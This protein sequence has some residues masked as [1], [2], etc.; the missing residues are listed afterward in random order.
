MANDISPM[1]ARL[2]GVEEA[3]FY[4]ALVNNMT[5]KPTELARTAAVVTGMCMRFL[6]TRGNRIDLVVRIVLFVSF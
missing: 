5:Y 3:R 4:L 2:A 6:A 1:N